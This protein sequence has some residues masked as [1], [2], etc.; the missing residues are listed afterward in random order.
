MQR[1]RFLTILPLGVTLVSWPG[2]LLS[3]LKLPLSLR[4]HIAG[5]K[6]QGIDV[7]NLECGMQVELRRGQFEG[8]TCFSVHAGGHRLGFLP[9]RLI[10]QVEGRQIRAASLSDVRPHAVPWKQL[11]VSLELASEKE[12]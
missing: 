7:A 11:E 4:F 3:L 5:V 6:Y 1:R 2:R 8:E 9:R 10:P 12:T